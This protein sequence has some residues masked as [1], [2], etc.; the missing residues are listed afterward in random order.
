[1]VC[2]N[3]FCHSNDVPITSLELAVYLHTY[4]VTLV[5][6]RIYHNVIVGTN[7]RCTPYVCAWTVED[8]NFVETFSRHP[9]K[10]TACYILYTLVFW[11]CVKGRH[12]YTACAQ[13]AEFWIPI[14]FPILLYLN[15]L[16]HFFNKYTFC[17][18]FH[19]ISNRMLSS[20][21]IDNFTSPVY[22]TKQ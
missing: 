15:S 7:L 9:A 10:P 1:M 5:T 2:L 21:V 13:I 6:Y 4:S 22:V 17:P 19:S 14:K 8:V 11:Y 18:I 20:K 16:E 3:Y 12:L